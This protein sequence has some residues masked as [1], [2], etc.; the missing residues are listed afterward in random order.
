MSSG[1]WSCLFVSLLICHKRLCHYVW[2]DWTSLLCCQGV[3]ISRCS[4][5]CT[6]CGPVPRR[7]LQIRSVAIHKNFVLPF[8]SSKRAVLPLP[9]RSCCFLNKVQNTPPPNGAHQNSRPY[10]FLCAPPHRRRQAR[11]GTTLH[12]TV[13]FHSVAACQVPPKRRFFLFFFCFLCVLG[14]A[15]DARQLPPRL[16][17]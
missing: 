17:W 16:R 10:Y 13:L 12:A 3:Q 6:L 5:F 9:S 4:T 7:I 11:T 14:A 15:F 2:G 1:L 8:L